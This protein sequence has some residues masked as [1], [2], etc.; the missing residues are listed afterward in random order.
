M[1]VVERMGG[2]LVGRTSRRSFLARS[3][4]VA[5]AASI[6]PVDFLLRPA[7]AYA[8]VCEC[9]SSNCSCS[10]ACCDGYTQFCCTIDGGVNACPPGSFAGGWWKADG[11]AYC[12]GARYYID[13]MGECHGCS[14]SGGF[15]F[16]GCDGLT[17]ECALGDCNNR[18]VGCTEFRYGQCHT[19]IACSGRILCRVVSCTPPWELDP[20]CSTV[21]QV[22]ESTANHY[23]PCQDGP[24]SF[25]PPAP[26]AVVAM[27]S[28]STGNG[29]WLVDVTGVVTA[30]G[31]AATYG[32]LAGKTLNKP[33][34]GMAATPDGKG[35]WLVASDGGIFEFGDAAFHGSTGN[36]HLN[37]PIVGMSTDPATGGYWLVASD[38]G[39]FDFDTPF[40][41]STGNVTLNKPVV[42]MA[43]M[44]SGA[45]YWLVASDGGIFE[46]GDAP[47]LGSTGNVT[48]NQPV[49]GMAATPTDK[50]YWLVAADGGIFEFGDAGFF[51]STGNV[52]LNKPIVGMAATPGGQGYWL[53]ASDGGVFNF[54]DA[55]FHGSRG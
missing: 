33:I 3:T 9:A 42:G 40:D 38:G 15:Q 49:V 25:A 41:G 10:Q 8:F 18:H 31:D 44:H 5:T 50:G 2:W 6:G 28:T 4:M 11:S 37:Q 1:T 36:V 43:A 54:G 55:T 13:C 47:F 34:V 53:V 45:G 12:A 17:C 21:S 23:A 30:Y 24:T 52:K 35:Y 27:A 14:C 32:D 51:G 16:C 26:P 19:E 29:Y 22:D 20:T 7:T 48:L 39:I 46:F